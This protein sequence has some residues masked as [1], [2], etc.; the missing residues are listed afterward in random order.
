MVRPNVQP[1]PSHGPASSAT[2]AASRADCPQARPAPSP[3]LLLVPLRRWATALGTA[4]ALGS[5]VVIL[6]LAWL[7]PWLSQRRGNAFDEVVLDRVHDALP[8]ALSP[9]LLTVYRLS[10]VHLTALLVLSV[11]MFLALRRLWPHL[12]CFTIG[13][14]G[15]LLIVDRW[16]KPFF[17]RRRPGDSPLELTGWAF[18]SGHAAGAVV[19]FGLLCILL[20][21]RYPRHRGLLTAACVLWV[22]LVWLSTLYARAHWLTDIVGGVAVGWVWLSFCLAGFRAWQRRAEPIEHS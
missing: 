14:G 2:A 5:V 9:L 12:V 3:A 18:P 19:F 21:A 15:I 7:G 22:A 13:T 16:L 8:A 20:G 10:G 17:D 4:Q 11:L 6:T 1:L